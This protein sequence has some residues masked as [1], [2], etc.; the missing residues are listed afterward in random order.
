MRVSLCPAVHGHIAQASAIMNPA[1]WSAWADHTGARRRK[2]RFTGPLAPGFRWPTV[3]GEKP[4]RPWDD[5]WWSTCSG[6]RMA[7]EIRGQS[8]EPADFGVS[9][10]TGANLCRLMSTRSAS[11][12]RTG[13]GWERGRPT[14]LRRE[15]FSVVSTFSAR[16]SACAA[17][18]YS[19]RSPRMWSSWRRRLAICSRSAVSLAGMLS[20]A[21][22]L[23]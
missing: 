3:L 9:L 19:S 13:R 17:C 4:A 5:H 12:A 11:F 16:A 2:K 21:L 14:W 20:C 18:L 1:G 7:H 22:A 15:S 23:A 6:P 10:W 8:R